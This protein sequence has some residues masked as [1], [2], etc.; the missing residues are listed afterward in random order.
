MWCRPRPF[1][2]KLFVRSLGFPKTK[3]CTKFKVCISSSFEDMFDRMPKIYGS[4][5][6]GHAHFRESYLFARSDSPRW[7]YVPNLKSLAHVVLKI[8][9]CMPKILGVTWLTIPRTNTEFARRSYSYS[10]P[11]IWNNLPGDVSNCNSEHTFK[12]HLKTFLF[13][14]CFYAAWLT[15]PLAPL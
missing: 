15:P 8:F 3:S 9:D 1:Y 6:L 14:S 10:A 12:K 7:S 13:N 4:R 5:D 11:F 2:G